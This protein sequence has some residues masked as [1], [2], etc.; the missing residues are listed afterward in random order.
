MAAFTRAAIPTIIALVAVHAQNNRGEISTAVPTDRPLRRLNAELTGALCSARRRIHKTKVVPQCVLKGPGRG[1][2]SR[3][4]HRQPDP[5]FRP[6]ETP[7]TY[8]SEQAERL[9]SSATGRLWCIESANG[10]LTPRPRYVRPDPSKIW[11]SQRRMR[12]RT[13]RRG[14]VGSVADCTPGR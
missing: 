8:H 3:S 7:Q 10:G 13:R 9:I 6:L 5:F 14:A 1:S 11:Q 12:A 2:G 4:R